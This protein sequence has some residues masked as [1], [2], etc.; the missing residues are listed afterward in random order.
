RRIEADDFVCALVR[1]A[2]EA[3]LFGRQGRL[4]EDQGVGAD[5]GRAG[6][7][8]WDLAGGLGRDKQGAANGHKRGGALQ[9]QAAEASHRRRPWVGRR[10][11]Q[12]LYPDGKGPEAALW[13]GGSFIRQRR[14]FRAGGS[15][16]LY[17]GIRPE[18]RSGISSLLRPGPVVFEA[19]IQT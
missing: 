11:L 17:P 9:R 19:A 1:A 13:R 7:E 6:R 15:G 18:R 10:G 8:V 12:L 5:N 2:W 16:P 4:A 14:R 3:V